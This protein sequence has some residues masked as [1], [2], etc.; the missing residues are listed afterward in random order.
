MPG[1]P[2]KTCTAALGFTAMGRGGSVL[3]VRSL[4]S[5]STCTLL[6]VM[7]MSQQLAWC[8]FKLVRSPCSHWQAACTCVQH[9]S[10]QHWLGTDPVVHVPLSHCALGATRGVARA[11]AV[12]PVRGIRGCS[13]HGQSQP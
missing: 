10:W 8:L 9:A 4:P 2:V 1:R 11:V 7:L 5:S 12:V 6:P 13:P 3:G